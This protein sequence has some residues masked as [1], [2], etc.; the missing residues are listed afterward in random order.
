M[1]EI[2]KE[3]TTERT[4]KYFLYMIF[5]LMLV[6][7]LDSYA[8]VF[9]GAIPSAIA[10]TFLTGKS[11]NVQNSIMAFAS[12][13]VSIGMYFLFFSHYLSDKLGRK[14]MLSLTVFG[15]ACAAFGMFIS[16]N[17][18]MYMIFVFFLSFFFSSDI[19]L[20][21]INEE[22]ESNKRAYYSN[23]ILMAGLLGPII[24]VISRFI[25]IKETDSFWQGMTIFPMIIGFPL[26]IIIYFTLKETKRYQLMKES[27]IIESRSF[28]EDIGSIFKTESRKPYTFL[29]LIVFLRGI[30]GI[31]IGLF[32]KYMDDVGTLTQDQITIVFLLVIFAVIIAYAINGFLADKIGR[33]PLLYLWSALAPISVLIWVFGAHNTENAFYL[34]LLGYSLTHISTWGAIGIIRLITI[35]ML[36]TDRRGTGIGFRSL[37]GG[38]GGTVGLILSGVIILFVGLGATFIIFVMGHFIVIPIAYLFLKETKGVELSEIK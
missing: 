12:G 16:L 27:R 23:I 28:K 24:M 22:V 5:I 35:E 15:M 2:N 36:P 19:W 1:S 21:Y 8:T 9:P 38:I 13:A 26:C 3:K 29:L 6:Q 18:I 30:S 25:F 33:K 17:F 34:V 11:E 31:Y 10:E 4:R 7:I 20:I 32:E 37:I 14:K